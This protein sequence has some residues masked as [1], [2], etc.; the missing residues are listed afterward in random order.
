LKNRQGAAKNA[1]VSGDELAF[2]EEMGNKINEIES[3]FKKDAVSY[4]SDNNQLVVDAVINNNALGRFI[5]DTGAS[6]VVISKEIAGR[7][8]LPEDDIGQE[9][10]IEMADGTTVNARP[11]I[12][13]SVKVGDAEVEDVEAAVLENNVVG[14]ADG[15]LGMSFLRNF[16]INVDAP[17]NKLILEQL[18]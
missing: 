7:L 5:V 13:K 3:N 2:F 11:V 9:I 17:S 16:I 12:L 1:E 8:G 18:L 15:L 6:I 10:E 4:T 14:G